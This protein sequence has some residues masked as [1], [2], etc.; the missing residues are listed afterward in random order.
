M[1]QN[2]HAVELHLPG[3]IGTAR[4][5]DMQKIPIT[6]F[7]L[8]IGYIGSVKWKEVSTD[9]YLR[10]YIYLQYKQNIIWGMTVNFYR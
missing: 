5:P 9:S 3:L 4:H 6:G 1:S 10:L 2:Q 7:S 8:K